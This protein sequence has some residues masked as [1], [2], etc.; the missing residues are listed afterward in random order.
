MSLFKH[1][2]T[3]WTEIDLKA[4]RHNFQALKK[5]TRGQ[6]VE[7]RVADGLPTKGIRV[8]KILGVVKA[9]S[10][11]HGML[12]VTKELI[13]L[14]VDFLGVSELA[15][16]IALRQK[17]IKKPILVFETPL[18]SMV[19]EYVNHGLIS[20]VCSDKVAKALNAYAR[21]TG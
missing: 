5:M 13:K 1:A 12:P 4:I 7:L 2:Y 19:K 11:G 8:P 10:Y 17:K 20:T 16:G 21:K 9:E 14:G 15:E 3:A 6:L 18:P